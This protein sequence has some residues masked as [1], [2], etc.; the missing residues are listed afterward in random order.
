VV[1]PPVV[2]PPPDQ[3]A[4]FTYAAPPATV[5]ETYNWT[6][7][8]IDSVTGLAPDLTGYAGDL[9]VRQQ[10]S[11]GIIL[12]ASTVNQLMT[13]NAGGVKGAVTFTFPPNLITQPGQFQYELKLVDATQ[14]VSKPIGGQLTVNDT[15]TP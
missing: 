15:I 12:E 6:I 1:P 11:S 2:P 9:Q 5:G 4:D 13:L 7:Q 8:L 14:N 3:M 10:A